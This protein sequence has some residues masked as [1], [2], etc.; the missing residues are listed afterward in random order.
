MTSASK[1][2]ALAF[3]DSVGPQSTDV[4]LYTSERTKARGRRAKHKDNAHPAPSLYEGAPRDETRPAQSNDTH[5][6]SSG[7]ETT[8]RAIANLPTR[9]TRSR[10]QATDVQPQQKQPSPSTVQESSVGELEDKLR[11]TVLDQVDVPQAGP[12][13]EQPPVAYRIRQRPVPPPPP[14][15]PSPHNFNQRPKPVTHGAFDAKAGHVSREFTAAARRSERRQ[16]TTPTQKRAQLLQEVIQSFKG[17]QKSFDLQVLALYEHQR[18]S[19]KVLR[20]RA[21]LISDLEDILNRY[22]FKWGHPHSSF[23]DPLVVES[24]G[25]ARFGLSTSTSDLDLCL[26]DPYR[27]DGFDQKYFSTNDEYTTRL[28][29]IYDMRTL[30]RILN[31][32]GFDKVVAISHA[33]VP[34]VKFECEIAGIRIQADLNTNER[35]G[36]YNSRLLAAY[37]DLHELIRPFCVFVKFWAAQRGLNDPSGQ[38]GPISFSSYTLLLLVIAYLQKTGVVPNLQDPRLIELKGLE[39]KLFWSRPKPYIKH[40]V[41]L[42]VTRSI[43]W[44]V[45]FVERLSTYELEQ[46]TNL[47]LKTLAAGFFKFY[48]EFDWTKFAVSVKNGQSLERERPYEDEISR[49]RKDRRREVEEFARASAETGRDPDEDDDEEEDEDDDDA[50][51]K[52]VYEPP[53]QKESGLDDDTHRNGQ[54]LADVLEAKARYDDSSR[55]SSPIA[56][57]EFEEPERW[58]SRLI[59]TQD[60]FDLTRNTCGNVEPDVAE[61]FVRELDRA[62]SLLDD[63]ADLEQLCRAVDPDLGEETLTAHRTKWRQAQAEAYTEA[64]EEIGVDQAEMVRRSMGLSLTARSDGSNGKKQR[65]R[66]SKK[67]SKA[68]QKP[69]GGVEAA[70]VEATESGPRSE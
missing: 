10:R 18:A 65:K 39:R 33:A 67:R 26:F 69:E 51:D 63:G 3:Q 50:G 46:A 17:K 13:D 43:G 44:D 15:L 21:R 48:A 19:P 1:H 61:K 36:V 60:P 22:R 11:R 47:T 66:R 59:V 6:R 5:E 40:G 56:Y 52:V 12:S 58:E 14:A 42:S 64:C 55:S 25:S 9:K 57:G 70:A 68:K 35:L 53:K 27:P 8:S 2:I 16:T 24:F 20:A 54:D 49:L 62:A 37:C 31:Q 7:G 34:I 45:T 30:A 38:D 29:E 41:V 23:T 4:D 28:P 32:A